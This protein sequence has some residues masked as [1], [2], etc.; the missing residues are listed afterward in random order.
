MDNWKSLL[1]QD[2][3]KWL[4]EDDNPSVRYFTLI[5]LL[6]QNEDDAEVKKTKKQ[7]ME[8][9]IVPLILE[10]QNPGG[11][12]FEPE[13]YYIKRK[14][15]GTVWNLIILA[16]LPFNEKLSNTGAISVKF[17]Q[18]V[19]LVFSIN[20]QKC[21][22]C[23]VCKSVCKANA[24]DYT[25]KDKKISLDVGAIIL[26]IGFDEFEP[27]PLVNLGYNK[28]LNVVTSIQFERILSA[29]G[30][31]AG[32]ILRPSDGIIP[33]KIAFLHCIG[34]RDKKCGVEYCSS[35][36][37]MYTTKE[38]M[39]AYE[40]DNELESYV[41]Y[42]DLRAGGKGFQKFL[43]RGAEEYNIK[44]IKSKISHIEV[45]VNRSPIITY[46]N[47]ETGEIK[48]MRF[49]LVVLATC[50]IPSLSNE[51]IA[52][53]L[54]VDLDKNRFIKTDPFF[55]VEST[56]PGI[57][58]CGC[59]REPMDIPRSVAEASGAAARAAELVKGG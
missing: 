27:A 54:G 18:A 7:I 4:L 26:A 30:P 38:A 52:K 37:C 16:E 14:Y 36:C 22:G 12:W 42:I 21:I 11:Y 6:E 57:Y 20:K 19:P 34:S 45:D 39:V 51:K 17:P 24:I 9:G 8:T 58:T 50:I 2:Q 41:F 25:L 59:A 49:D 29:S 55:P 43:L 53:I 3:T 56:V 33:R 13:N 47:L 1:K 32:L 44:Y 46:E 48:Q 31:H 15:K 40:H 10:K 35:V 5:D 28:F 23:E